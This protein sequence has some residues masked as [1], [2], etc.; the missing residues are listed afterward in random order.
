MSEHT[1]P[2]DDSDISDRA[3]RLMSE[4]LTHYRHLSDARKT[5]FNFLVALNGFYFGVVIQ[6]IWDAPPSSFEK[7]A[8]LCAIGAVYLINHVISDAISSES[9]V[10]AAYEHMIFQLQK[11]AFGDTPVLSNYSNVRVFLPDFENRATLPLFNSLQSILPLLRLSHLALILSYTI[12]LVGELGI[13]DLFVVSA[14]FL[15]CVMTVHA[16]AATAVNLSRHGSAAKHIE[17]LPD[18]LDII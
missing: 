13:S 10:M 6:N 15:S 8:F 4:C 18:I 16:A 9:R 5:Y 14:V 3:S 12:L 1:S 17:Q 2:S 7:I 11:V